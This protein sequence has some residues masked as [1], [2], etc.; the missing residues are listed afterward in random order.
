[1]TFGSFH[2]MAG[3][4]ECVVQHTGAS[5]QDSF[6]SSEWH[7]GGV[8]QSRYHV[9]ATVC[10]SADSKNRRASWLQTTSD[11]ITSRWTLER[12]TK[13]WKKYLFPWRLGQLVKLEKKESEKLM[14]RV[15]EWFGLSGPEGQ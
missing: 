15:I 14:E 8:I 9:V 10:E 4:V 5:E 11:A 2:G 6:S 3:M 7:S 13:G 12:C 1:M